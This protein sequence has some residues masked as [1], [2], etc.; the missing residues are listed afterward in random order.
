MMVSEDEQKTHDVW[1][2]TRTRATDGTCV[3]RICV[4]QKGVCTKCVYNSQLV[5][6]VYNVCTI[7]VYNSPH[8]LRRDGRNVII[9]VAM[10]DGSCA[11]KK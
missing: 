1:S 2:P 10:G 4:T 5:P 11:Y 9:I 3:A 6:C 7:R 8:S